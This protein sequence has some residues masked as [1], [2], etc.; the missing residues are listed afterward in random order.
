MIA[1]WSATD[2][3]GLLDNLYDVDSKDGFEQTI[4]ERFGVLLEADASVL[5]SQVGGETLK[6]DLW[7]GDALWALKP[8][9]FATLAFDAWLN[10][11]SA[12]RAGHVLLSDDVV[13][14]DDLEKTSFYEI[15]LK[16]GEYV[17]GLNV[18]LEA[19]MPESPFLML[20]RTRASGSFGRDRAMTLEQVS[21]HL[22][23]ALRIRRHLFSLN[24]GHSTLLAA[25]ESTATPLLVVDTNL[26]VR[27]LSR[28]ARDLLAAT[29]TLSLA[30]DQLVA[31]TAEAQAKL[32]AA[33]S[34]ASEPSAL[35][36]EL[37]VVMLR[38]DGLFPT[39]RLKAIPLPRAL[40]ATPSGVPRC[41][42]VVEAALADRDTS[43]ASIRRRFSLTPAES[44]VA[45]LLASGMTAKQIGQQLQVSAE[46]VRTHLKR[47]FV[48]T[49]TKRQAELVVRLLSEAGESR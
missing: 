36:D 32:H 5:V 10:R 42:L 7:K 8:E 9:R 25:I 22:V 30:N 2:L 17:H 43:E 46:T 37:Q 49:G 1:P 27:M 39:L 4:C 6:M 3:L 19:V 29:D 41:L 28:P 12:R 11:A 21:A 48:K 13:L 34:K 45:S 18:W 23:N 20:M 26:R 15:Y 14:T 24:D 38:S 33:I 47:I 35:D 40:R 44:R 16:S 31:S